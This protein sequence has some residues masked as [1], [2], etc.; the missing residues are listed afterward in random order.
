NLGVINNY[1]NPNKVFSQ[2]NW[3]LSEVPH[4]NSTAPQYQV[5]I[6]AETGRGKVLKIQ[7]IP[8]SNTTLSAW[9][10]NLYAV[11]KIPNL[12]TLWNNRTTGNDIL[13]YECEFYLAFEERFPSP[14]SLQFGLSRIE[15]NETINIKPRIISFE[16]TG[17]TSEIR[18]EASGTGYPA[19]PNIPLTAWKWTKIIMY[20]N[21]TTGFVH[22]EVPS[23]NTAYKSN[24][25]LPSQY[26]KVF[27]LL[28]L[29][30]SSDVASNN[31]NRLPNFTKFDNL[32]I[33]AVN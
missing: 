23:V 14:P 7:D 26:L 31:G 4:S 3:Q 9:A 17:S 8:I 22:F 6:E 2:G 16:Y 33:S 20:V 5:T 24:T 29:T 11:K 15:S 27:N 21:Y 12:D 13:K 1:A 10:P 25:P 30:F 19:L 32:K 18:G 28:N